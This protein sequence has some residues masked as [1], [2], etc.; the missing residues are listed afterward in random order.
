VS[1]AVRSVSFVVRSE[2]I[3][4]VRA[5]NGEW[6]TTMKREDERRR[7]IRRRGGRSCS[8]RWRQIRVLRG[9]REL[10]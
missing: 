10:L 7:L 1:F 6:L 9:R 3:A 5:A 4:V 8:V 2:S